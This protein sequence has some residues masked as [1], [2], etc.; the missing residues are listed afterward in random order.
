MFASSVVFFL[1]SVLA[2]VGVVLIVAAYSAGAPGSLW[3]R[4]RE[5]FKLQTLEAAQ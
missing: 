1:G 3:S 5:L 4:L 2:L